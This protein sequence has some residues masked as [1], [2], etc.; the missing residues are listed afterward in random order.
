[1]AH[2][3][4][5]TL[6]SLKG[7]P[8]GVVLTEPLWGI[9]Y[10]LFAPYV[11][12]YMLSLGMTDRLIGLTVSIS[13]ILQIVWSLLGG[14][15][16]DKMGRKRA[17]LVFD[18]LSWS[19][20]C[21]VWAVAQNFTY[22]LVAAIFNSTWRISMTAWT[23]LLV[24]DSEPRQLVDIYSWIYISGLLA[25]F[26]APLAG[27]LVQTFSLV[28]TMRGLYLLAVVM[29][30][31]KFFIMNGMVTETAQG[32]VRM[33]ETRHQRLREILGE[34]RQIFARM[35][36][37]PRTL[38]ALGILAVMTIASTINGSFWSIIAAEKIGI[39]LDRLAY[40]PFARSILMLVFYFLVIPRIS[41]KPFKRPMLAGFCAYLLSHLVLVLVP[42]KSYLLLLVSVLLEACAVAVLSPFLDR[43]VAVSIEPE[44]RARILSLVYVAVI[45]LSSPFGW[46][47]G[48][49]SSINR[50]LPFVLTMSLFALG[51]LLVWL[52]SRFPEPVVEEEILLTTE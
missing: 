6:K 1:M 49:L 9:S 43:L 2:P 3:L 11:S 8:R 14:I 26:F 21:L 25:A 52:A 40:Y 45:M 12:L 41:G 16:T 13:M 36:A 5:A 33:H 38:A 47:A 31:A 35:L 24:E 44:E 22:F 4:I 15:T 48:T 34:Y 30:T 46:I 18:L 27:L 19:V 20:P 23:C 7:N 39:P 51:A 29:M 32:R 17:T 28:P 37:A 42:Q 10:N 50:A